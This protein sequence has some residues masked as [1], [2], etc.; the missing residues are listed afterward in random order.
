MFTTKERLHD[1]PSCQCAA[2]YYE[3]AVCFLPFTARKAFDDHRDVSG[4]NYYPST[5]AQHISQQD[6][7]DHQRQVEQAEWEQRHDER[8]DAER[9]SQNARTAQGPK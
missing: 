9:R 2:E 3:C 5:A 7:Q 6:E 8:M 4:H 1:C